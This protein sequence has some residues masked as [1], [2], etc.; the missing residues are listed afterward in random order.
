MTKFEKILLNKYVIS[1]RK[2]FTDIAKS[3][4][5]FNIYKTTNDICKILIYS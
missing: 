2:L 3:I 4:I 5:E 1:G